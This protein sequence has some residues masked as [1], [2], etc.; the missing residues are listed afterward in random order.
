MNTKTRR[1]GCGSIFNLVALLVV[2]A[3]I[4]LLGPLALRA[5]AQGITN[6]TQP[7]WYKSYTVVVPGYTTNSYVTNV[8][9]VNMMGTNAVTNLVTVPLTNFQD[10]LR[11][12]AGEALWLS[13]SASN[14]ATATVTAGFDLTP[15]GFTWTTGQPLSESATLNGT[16]QVMTYTNNSSFALNSARKI[17][18][19]RLANTHTNS[20]TVT[21][22]ASRP[23]N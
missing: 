15:D 8:P 5:P 10:V 3:I 6:V 11:M 17:A 2:M 18:L 21:V 4:S 12:N 14:T 22:W 13:A 19:T 16:N 23:N 7:N 20:V 9:A 1:F